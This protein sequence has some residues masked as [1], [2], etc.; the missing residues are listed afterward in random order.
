MNENKKRV[1]NTEEEITPPSSSLNTTTKIEPYQSEKIITLNVGGKR[2]QIY[3]SILA[4]LPNSML[5]RMF[6]PSEFVSI[7]KPND[8][9]GVSYF[10]SRPSHLFKYILECY[11]YGTI[12]TAPPA[13]VAAEH[14]YKELLFWGLVEENFIVGPIDEKHNQR[15]R[16]CKLIYDE[17]CN[18][19][20]DALKSLVVVIPIH[21]GGRFRPIA[22][23]NMKKEDRKLYETFLWEYIFCSFWPVE[24]KNGEFYVFPNSYSYCMTPYDFTEIEHYRMIWKTL[25]VRSTKNYLPIILRRAPFSDI[26]RYYPLPLWEKRNHSYSGTPENV[27]IVHMHLEFSTPPPNSIISLDVI[28]T[29]K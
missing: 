12:S 14:W 13:G 23:Q 7:A 3:P 19:E 29:E 20:M 10:F 4:T 5:A 9:D 18:E 16:V 11:Y 27:E 2:F 22:S 1:H 25:G 24:E 8:G 26:K 28:H 17:M 15:E 6:S 21:H